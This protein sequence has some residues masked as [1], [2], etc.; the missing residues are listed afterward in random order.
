MG[1]IGDFIQ[2]YYAAHDAYWGFV[3]YAGS[4]SFWILYSLLEIARTTVDRLSRFVTEEWGERLIRGWDE[5]WYHLPLTVGDRLGVKASGG[6]RDS[7]KA[8]AMVEA[9]A[10]RIGTS[11]TAAILAGLG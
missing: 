11:S 3:W 7:K 6:I 2:G 1:V 8:L 9:G 10:N 4:M 5:G